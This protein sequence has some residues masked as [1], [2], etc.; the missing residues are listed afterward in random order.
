M[1]SLSKVI[2]LIML[3]PL[4][5]MGKFAIYSHYG[6]VPILPL[7]VITGAMSILTFNLNIVSALLAI[8]CG[9]FWCSDSG[10]NLCTRSAGRHS[11][12][13]SE[14]RAVRALWGIAGCAVYHP[15]LF[16][17]SSLTLFCQVKLCIPLFLPFLCGLR[18]SLVRLQQPQ[19][20]DR[21]PLYS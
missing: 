12:N 6:F 5:V 19:W 13:D 17:F 16:R 8:C 1:L 20:R 11:S 18:L 21:L 2:L 4:N 10:L 9:H 15:H 3:L 7:A 14:P